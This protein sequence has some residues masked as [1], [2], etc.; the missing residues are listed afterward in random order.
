[1]MNDQNE[2]QEPQLVSCNKRQKRDF[3]KSQEDALWAWVSNTQGLFSYAK[4]SY[5]AVLLHYLRVWHTFRMDQFWYCV[6]M[7]RDYQ[8]D[9]LGRFNEPKD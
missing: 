4:S 5:P 7:I 3:T 1:M 9:Q 8:D 6:D 2:T